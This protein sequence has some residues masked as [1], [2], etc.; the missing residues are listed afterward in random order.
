MVKLIRRWSDMT[1]AIQDDPWNHDL[2]RALILPVFLP[3]EGTVSTNDDNE[4][5]DWDDAAKT[6]EYNYKIHKFNKCVIYQ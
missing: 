1:V 5:E 4:A 2:L 3:F 6:E